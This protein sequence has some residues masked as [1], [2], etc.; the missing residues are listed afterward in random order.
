MRGPEFSGYS[1]DGSTGVSS[2]KV[3]AQLQ[4]EAREITFK[5]QKV[6]YSGPELETY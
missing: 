2:G 1:M 3:T 5:D 4:H 6:C